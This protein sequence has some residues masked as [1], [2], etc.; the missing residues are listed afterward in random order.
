M[1]ADDLREAL[2]QHRRNLAMLELQRA[3]AGMLAPLSLLNEI[4]FAEEQ[5]AEIERKLDVDALTHASDRA[6]AVDNEECDMTTTSN[7]NRWTRIETRLDD[8]FDLL[9][10]M[11]IEQAKAN[12]RTEGVERRVARLESVNSRPISL[13]P[14]WVMPV[15]TIVFL[16]ITIGLTLTLIWSATGG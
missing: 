12:A 16:A 15:G 6:E 13:L 14:G 2:A 8:L 5:I 4:E 10:E 3:S 1:E 11:K 9:T 7:G